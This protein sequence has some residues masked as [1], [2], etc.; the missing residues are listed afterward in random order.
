MYVSVASTVRHGTCTESGRAI[1]EGH[2]AR[3]V[4]RERCCEGHGLT[5][6]RGISGRGE[7]LRPGRPSLPFA[8]SFRWQSYW[9]NPR[10]R[11]R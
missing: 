5:E 9:L 8:L 3:R 4:R 2:C 6:G 11:L 1:G 10:C 7:S